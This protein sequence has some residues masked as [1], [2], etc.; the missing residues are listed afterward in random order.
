MTETVL[1][2]AKK[3][4]VI[5]FDRPFVVIG[6]RI[7]PT[8]RK[9]LATEM[10]AGNHSRVQTD[11]L[12]Q[13][14]AGAHVLDVNVG[15]PMADEA[16]L[17]AEIIG[18]VQSL[19]DVPLGIDS[20]NA[21]ALAAGLSTYQGKALVN[22]VT[23]EE[24]SLES[25]LPLVKKYGAAVIGISHDDDGISSDPHVRVAVARKIVERAVDHGIPSCD[26]VIDPAVMPIGVVGESGR[27]VREVITRIRTDLKLNTVCGASNISFGLPNRT[28]LNATFLSMAIGDGLTS[29]IA[30]PLHEE[31][32]AAIAAAEVMLGMDPRCKRWIKR[33]RRLDPRGGG[34]PRDRQVQDA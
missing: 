21:A 30:N 9:L 34:R 14:A 8:G 12:A 13:V 25:V 24:A 33:A 1:S 29:A 5:G 10:A 26:V 7:N 2:S 16:K 15:V 4:V 3:E 11:A 19:T 32:T 20:S 27:I 22:S 23:G 28:Q 31:I 17:M 18:L 6:E